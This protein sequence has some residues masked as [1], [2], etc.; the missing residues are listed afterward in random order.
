MA[1]T[2]TVQMKE[3][4]EAYSK[5]V[6][7][8][9]QAAIQRVGRET[10]KKLRSTSPKRPKGGSYAKGWRL[11]TVQLRGDVCDF[12][13]HNATDYQLTHLLE[14]GH[15]TVNKKGEFGRTPAHVHI[16]PVEEWANEELPR[17]IEK[18]LGK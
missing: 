1:E 15:R 8:A 2:I 16:K 11:K 3:I 5:E 10:V 12:V 7:H 18:E 14:R 4:M 6:Q 13:V 9:S 17:E